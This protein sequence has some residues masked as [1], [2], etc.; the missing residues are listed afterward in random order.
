M[1]QWVKVLRGERSGS[2]VN[3]SPVMSSEWIDL[4]KREFD[5]V[6][7]SVWPVDLKVQ[8]T[9]DAFVFQSVIVCLCHFRK[10]LCVSCTFESTNTLRLLC[11]L[12]VYTFS[13]YVQL[14]Q[15]LHV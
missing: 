8:S 11:V 13:L 6:G 15:M 3:E 4:L 1:D 12:H 10:N 5:S 7:S 2:D 9:H 14:A